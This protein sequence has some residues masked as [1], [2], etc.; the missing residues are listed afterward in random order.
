MVIETFLFL[1]CKEIEC[2]H[3]ILRREGA[4]LASSHGE[5]VPVPVCPEQGHCFLDLSEEKK[6]RRVFLTCSPSADLFW[7]VQTIR[8]VIDAGVQKRYVCNCLLDTVIKLY[9]FLVNVLC[10]TQCFV[11]TG[12]QP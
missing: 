12:V 8:F 11:V 4:S 10:V 6:I 9:Y 2:A 7:A 1:F 5:M 3:A